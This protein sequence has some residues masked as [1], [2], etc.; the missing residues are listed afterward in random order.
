MVFGKSNEWE[1]KNYNTVCSSLSLLINKWC[2]CLTAISH[3][4]LWCCSEYQ[5]R[6][7]YVWHYRFHVFMWNLCAIVINNLLK[8]GSVICIVTNCIA[9]YIVCRF[10]YC[11][12]VSLYLNLHKTQESSYTV[13]QLILKFFVCKCSWEQMLSQVNL[14]LV[15]TFR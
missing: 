2:C 10:T 7:D 3:S 9:N 1:N 15:L 5:H 12:W 14:F 6:C 13:I 4:R 8:P 11:K